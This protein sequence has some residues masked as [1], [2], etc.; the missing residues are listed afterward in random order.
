MMEA[1]REFRGGVYLTVDEVVP[2]GEESVEIV[3]NGEV[4]Y[5]AG[6]LM[7]PARPDSRVDMRQGPSGPEPKPND[8]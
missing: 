4:F 6:D 2:Y 7:I 1:S 8:G 5:Q 3:I